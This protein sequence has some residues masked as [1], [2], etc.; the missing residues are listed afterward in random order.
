METFSSGGIKI[1][2]DDI[3][4]QAPAKGVVVLVHG[5]ATNRDEN[6]K[7]LGWYTAFSRKGFRVLAF[8]HR[9]HGES[10]KPHDA[11]NYNRDAMA[12]DIT[13]LMD[14]VGV[15]QADLMGYSMGGRLSLE[16][17][18]N[19]PD[20]FTT[21]V[22]GGIGGRMLPNAEPPPGPAPTMTMAQAMQAED[23]SVITDPT[24]KGFRQF[25]D[26][27]GDD[28]LA[29]AACSQGQGSPL[30]LDRLAGLAMP[31][32]VVAG[33]RDQLAGDP[34]ALADVIPGAK[35]VT[36]PGCDHFSAIPHA[37]YKSAVFDFYEGWLD[38]DLPEHLR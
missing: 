21:L 29:L 27:Q 19:H 34:Q 1:A 33:S 26:Q 37:L 23:P 4:P 6:W 14:H 15:G 9:G 11:A 17:A 22:V 5:F 20:R 12:A 25:A 13:G 8:D 10:D 32:L 2:Y 24:M 36:L 3:A 31:V 30:D 35:S 28:R 38:E 18:L 16:A 7:R